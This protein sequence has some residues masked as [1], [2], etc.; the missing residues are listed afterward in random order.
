MLHSFRLI[1]V[2]DWFE[3][4]VVFSLKS[5]DDHL[6]FT[7]MSRPGFF[8]EVVSVHG[9][10][11]FSFLW[12]PAMDQVSW[13]SL[14]GHADLLWLCS[15]WEGEIHWTYCVVASNLIF[16]CILE[17]V[18]IFWR[19]CDYWCLLYALGDL[20]M[21]RLP[22]RRRYANLVTDPP[23]FGFILTT[24]HPETRYVR[25]I[26]FRFLRKKDIGAL[27]QMSMG[28]Y[29]YIDP[30]MVVHTPSVANVTE[31]SLSGS[32]IENQSDS[33]RSLQAESTL[34][35]QF[36][37]SASLISSDRQIHDMDLPFV[38]PRRSQ[39]SDSVD[40]SP[41]N[42]N[43]NEGHPALAFESCMIDQQLK[44]VVSCCGCVSPC[45]SAIL[46]RFDGCQDCLDRLHFF[47]SWRRR[48]IAF[49]LLALF[50]NA[51]RWAEIN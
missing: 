40:W 38:V 50:S 25:V 29:W 13:D 2:A 22:L 21:I 15:C 37:L 46:L 48:T 28:A 27:I 3:D 23:V 49:L 18:C 32:D 35:L 16:H 51:R 33:S 42:A 14:I 10:D 30:W 17:I 34:H 44:W 8:V 19:W 5:N 43:K 20:W 12:P 41:A 47:V 9:G 11:G 31:D 1:G 24:G 6:S 36:A 26:I 4:E 39:W 7:W 45:A